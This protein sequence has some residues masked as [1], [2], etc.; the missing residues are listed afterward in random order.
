MSGLERGLKGV[1]GVTLSLALAGCIGGGG[2]GSSGGG[3]G[4]G[5]GGNTGGPGSETVM[6]QLTERQRFDDGGLL[7]QEP[8]LSGDNAL[9][10]GELL[11]HG[12]FGNPYSFLAYYPI[13]GIEHCA[14]LCVR[15]RRRRARAHGPHRRNTHRGLPRPS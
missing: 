7:D 15:A 6:L 12:R 11:L 1:A 3:S 4:G 8:D 13:V 14:R 2:G 10:A 5:S 9:L